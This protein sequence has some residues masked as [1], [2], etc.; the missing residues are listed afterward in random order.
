MKKSIDWEVATTFEIMQDSGF[1]LWLTELGIEK[2][3]TYQT[4]KYREIMLS[5]KSSISSTDEAIKQA[6]LAILQK[7]L[8]PEVDPLDILLKEA[9]Y[10]LAIQKIEMNRPAKRNVNAGLIS[11]AFVAM[12]I[13]AC[14]IASY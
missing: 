8:H 13:F 7:K 10:A 6:K 12:F 3:G 11:F 9:K 2:F 4:E 14:F 1:K 5:G